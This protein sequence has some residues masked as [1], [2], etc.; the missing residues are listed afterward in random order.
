MRTVL[1]R[2]EGVLDRVFGVLGGIV[3]A[4]AVSLAALYAYGVF[5]FHFVILVAAPLL[6]FPILSVLGLMWPLYFNRFSGPVLSVFLEMLDIRCQIANVG[7]R[8]LYYFVPPTHPTAPQPLTLS[9][10]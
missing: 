2:I 7:Y 10:E 6:A 5:R 9:L 3:C 8:P 4:V 1:K